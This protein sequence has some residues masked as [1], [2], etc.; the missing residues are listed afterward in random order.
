M[1]HESSTSSMSTK[2]I[3]GAWLVTAL[4]DV[5]IYKQMRG[6]VAFIVNKHKAWRLC[7]W[8][9]NFS[10]P[11]YPQRAAWLVILRESILNILW[12]E[13]VMIFRMV[14]RNC[15]VSW[16]YELKSLRVLEGYRTRKL[17]ACAIT[18]GTVIDSVHS[19]I[20]KMYLV[21]C[22]LYYIWEVS[23]LAPVYRIL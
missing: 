13:S 3:K 23:I 8:S 14:K 6:R 1:I 15:A 2:W 21:V 10:L 22:F 4:E 11:V 19:S 18:T 9:W 16:Y 17:A 12:A 7:G 5:D 20:K